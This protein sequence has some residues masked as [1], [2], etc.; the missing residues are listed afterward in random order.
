GRRRRGGCATRS[1]RHQPL[2]RGSASPE[3]RFLRPLV[4]WTGPSVCRNPYKPARRAH[5]R[6]R[7]R[8]KRS[9]AEVPHWAHKLRNANLF[10]KLAGRKGRCYLVAPVRSVGVVL[11]SVVAGCAVSRAGSAPVSAAP[12]PARPESLYVSVAYPAPTDVVHWHDSAF[13][14]GAVRGALGAVHLGVIGQSV[15]VLP[16]G[17]WIA[18]VPLPDHTVATFLLAPTAAPYS[19]RTVLP[20]HSV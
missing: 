3:S 12:P 9:Q 8:C 5:Y 14:F 11:A 7:S 20:G 6:G 1:R 13:L 15:P 10:D 18:W 4:P 17:G 19:T 16:G 2:L